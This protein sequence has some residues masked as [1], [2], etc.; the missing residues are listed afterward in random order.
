MALEIDAAEKLIQKCRELC[1]SSIRQDYS[2]DE[3][4]NACFIIPWKTLSGEARKRF[5]KTFATEVRQADA[6]ARIGTSVVRA[7]GYN[8]QTK[9]LYSVVTKGRK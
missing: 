5:G 2:I 4:W 9:M 1:A 3:L 6:N 7:I 8:A